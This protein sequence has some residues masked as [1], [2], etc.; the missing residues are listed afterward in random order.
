[1]TLFKNFPVRLL[2]W[3][4]LLVAVALRLEI[5]NDVKLNGFDEH[6][7]LRFAEIFHRDGLPGIRDLTAQYATNK[8]LAASPLPLRIGFVALAAWMCELA[9]KFSVENIAWISL[10][11]GA[12]LVVVSYLFVQRIA[13]VAE[14]LLVAALLLSSPL[15]MT[16]SRRALQDGLV[17]FVTVCI[18]YF[19]H[20]CWRRKRI[21]D[22]LM[23]AGLVAAALLLKEATLFIY[24]S[25][26]LAAIYY[27]RT[28]P[29]GDWKWIAGALA[30]GPLIYLGVTSAVAGGFSTW[31]HVYRE[32]TAMQ[33]KLPYTM[34]FGRGAWFRYFVDFLLLSPVPFLLAI[35]GMAAPVKTDGQRELKALALIYFLS[36]V[37]VFGLLPV[38]AVRVVL[39]LD[40]FLRVL[41]MLAACWLGRELAARFKLQPALAV[42]AVFAVLIGTDLWQ[43]HQLFNVANVYDPTTFEL[44]RGNGFWQHWEPPAQ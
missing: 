10:L 8:E 35:F 18:L 34:D 29:V 20:Q 38:R 17:G 14:G 15:A 43:F 25:L 12:G 33:S 11:A 41:A 44:I 5:F 13:G 6:A 28:K 36:G 32:Y 27:L 30:L 3:L 2:P 9:G 19:F 16:L 23:L 7:Y 39:Y 1:M 31:L 26:L 42:A 40:L 4:L 21:T 22:P 37:L 24:P